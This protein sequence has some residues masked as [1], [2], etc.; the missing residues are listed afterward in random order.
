MVLLNKQIIDLAF[1][2]FTLYLNGQVTLYLLG[3]F[4]LISTA[5]NLLYKKDVLL[6]TTCK[7][8]Y[9]TLITY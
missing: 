4:E 7:Y 9:K 8:T 5:S 6:I 3:N 2:S 1:Y